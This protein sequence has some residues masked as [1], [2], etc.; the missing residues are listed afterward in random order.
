MADDFS[1]KIEK[2]FG[3]IST[4]RGG[5]STELNLVSWNGRQAKYDIR[6]WDENHEK[7][8][9]GLTLTT[10]EIKALKTLL[11]SMNLE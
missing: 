8:G 5:W 10:E 3:T 6:S 7:M 11:N 1:Y 4:G 2:N 9:K